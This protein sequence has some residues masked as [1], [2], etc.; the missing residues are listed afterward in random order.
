MFSTWILSNQYIATTLLNSLLQMLLHFFYELYAV[1][2]RF[3]MYGRV[4]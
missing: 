3:A 1:L 2:I 4:K